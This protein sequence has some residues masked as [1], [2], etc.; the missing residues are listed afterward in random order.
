MRARSPFKIQ[1]DEIRTRNRVIVWDLLLGDFVSERIYLLRD[2]FIQH[3][4][5][6]KKAKPE[7][8]RAKVFR[9]S[10]ELPLFIIPSRFIPST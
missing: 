8:F 2:P 3:N 10:F 6:V 9:A 5:L 4:D 7:K 1:H